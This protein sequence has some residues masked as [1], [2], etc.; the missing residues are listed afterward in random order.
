[1]PTAATHTLTVQFEDVD[2]YRMVHHT[3]LIAYL[4]RARVQMLC[5]LGIGV[6]GPDFA[7]V[8]HS[9]QATFIAP[10]RFLDVLTVTTSVG[11]LDELRV[12][13][14]S[15]IHQDKRL[16][17]KGTVELA[18]IDSISGEIIPV[19]DCITKAARE[20]VS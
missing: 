6:T 9:L 16:I 1:M 3:K 5:D 14:A 7:V 17:A 11:D 12:V 2:S 19:P 8:V 13:L 18:F 4:E 20:A 15:K 10:A